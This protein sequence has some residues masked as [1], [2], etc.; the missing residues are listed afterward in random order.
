MAK[1]PPTNVSL[2]H[3]VISI[4]PVQVNGLYVLKVTQGVGNRCFHVYEVSDCSDVTNAVERFEDFVKKSKLVGRVPLEVIKQS[5]LETRW[6]VTVGYEGKN[7]GSSPALRE[8]TADEV[9]DHVVARPIN[10]PPVPRL[11]LPPKLEMPVNRFDT[12]RPSRVGVKK[13][14]VDEALKGFIDQYKK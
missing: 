7:N 13:L 12:F 6:A 3:F 4:K 14:T 11:K 5:L 8:A 9:L 10:R 2:D 1:K